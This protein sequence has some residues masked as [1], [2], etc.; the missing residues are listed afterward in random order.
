MPTKKPH[1]TAGHLSGCYAS[2]PMN[3][4]AATTTAAPVHEHGGQDSASHVI[5]A[6]ASREDAVRVDVVDVADASGSP[7]SVWL[8]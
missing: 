3:S 7:V 6:T 4:A 1:I 8:H 5:G 2:A